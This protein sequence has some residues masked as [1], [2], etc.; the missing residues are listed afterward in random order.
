MICVSVC[1]VVDMTNNGIYTNTKT[2]GYSYT[3]LF[4]QMCVHS[5]RRRTAENGSLLNKKKCAALKKD[6][7]GIEKA[8][9]FLGEMKVLE[10]TLVI[11]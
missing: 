8:H 11:K 6:P 5:I 3:C 7:I 9:K 1:S 4:R 2:S 10:V